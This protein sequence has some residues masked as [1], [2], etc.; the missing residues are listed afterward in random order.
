M[1]I[2][3]DPDQKGVAWR[4]KAHVARIR[5]ELNPTR[6]TET[7]SPP[8]IPTARRLREEKKTKTEGEAAAGDDAAKDEA[9]EAEVKAAEVK[10]ELGD[11][12]DAPAP[13]EAAPAEGAAHDATPMDAVGGEGVALDPPRGRPRGRA[14]W[15]ATTATNSNK[16]RGDQR[17]D[18][19]R[20]ERR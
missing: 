10:A 1:E 15:R 16:I 4:R 2:K 20:R 5:T 17:D 14:S 11:A 9:K 18:R 3:E 13:E 7:T 12:A 6:A 8:P 19:D